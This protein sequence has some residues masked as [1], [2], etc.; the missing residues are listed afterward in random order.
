MCTLQLFS[1]RRKPIFVV[2]H[3]CNART[4]RLQEDSLIFVAMPFI[5]GQFP[6]LEDVKKKKKQL[7]NFNNRFSSCVESQG[8]AIK[9]V[10]ECAALQVV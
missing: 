2:H 3:L 10:S 9:I 1:A 7:Q 6:S 5:E 4:E 8:A